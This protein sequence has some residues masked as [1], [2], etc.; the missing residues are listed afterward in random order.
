MSSID[1]VIR[2]AL[3]E[4]PAPAP[5]VPW[6]EIERRALR[7]RRPRWLGRGLAL[8]AA[9]LLVAG[10]LLLSGSLD[11]AGTSPLARA[12]AAVSSWPPDR[13]LHL[14]ILMVSH[15][16]QPDE[17][18]ESWQRTSAPFTVRRR[19]AFPANGSGRQ[20]VESVASAN[21]LGQLY[22]WR[23]RRVVRTTHAP[24]PWRPLGI[25]QQTR[26][27]LKAMLVANRWKPLG[28][29]TIDGHR[30]LGFSVSDARLYIDSTTYLPVLLRSSG[31]GVGAERR[32]YDLRYSWELL[33]AT[34]DNLHLLDLTFE[35]PHAAVVSRGGRAWNTLA[36]RLGR[37]WRP[38]ITPGA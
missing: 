12:S 9:A 26:D 19:T 21:G 36:D 16:N 31:I 11:R 22:D 27:E 30:V 17:L 2:R 33:P 28:A 13:I 6:P 1:S 25:E 37:A 29:S 35:H 32:G 24:A 4:L 8:G 10:A 14:R 20:V 18:E 7:A 15:F 5:L 34:R 23:S 38:P 3:E